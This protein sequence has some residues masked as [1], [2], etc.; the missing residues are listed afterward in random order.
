MVTVG[1]KTIIGPDPTF[2]PP[3][4]P[5]YHSHVAPVPKVPPATERVT[6][7][8]EQIELFDA[9]EPEGSVEGVSN[10]IVVEAQL[11]VL[12]IAPLLLLH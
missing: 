12:L 9:E 2:V 8:P 5:V 4:L 1:F 6:G 11:V 7:S 3:Q 10:V